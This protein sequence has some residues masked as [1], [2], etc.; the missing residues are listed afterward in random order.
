MTS[1]SRLTSIKNPTWSNEDHTSIDCM[2][3]TSQFGER[4]L[5]FTASPNDPSPHGVKIFNDLVSG[6]YGEIAPFVQVVIEQPVWE[7]PD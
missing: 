5:P 7:D 3:T 4:E 1:V 6:A 2:I